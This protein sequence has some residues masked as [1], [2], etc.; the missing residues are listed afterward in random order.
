MTTQIQAPRTTSWVSEIPEFKK[1]LRGELLLPSDPS[2]DI[3][4]KVWNGMIDRRPGMILRCAGVADVIQAVKFARKHRLIVAVRG[5]G[6]NVAGNA[7]CDDGIVI[8][9]SRMRS[10]RVDPAGRTAVAEEERHGET[11]TTRHKRS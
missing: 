8:D 11:L 1:Q 10:V 4:R 9:M 3:A 7:V 2:Y 6:H 5:G